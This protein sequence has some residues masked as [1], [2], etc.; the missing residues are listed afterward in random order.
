MHFILL[1]FKL[2]WKYTLTSTF[3]LSKKSI[4]QAV[5]QFI[6]FCKKMAFIYMQWKWFNVGETRDYHFSDN[7]NLEIREP[8]SWFVCLR[9]CLW[10]QV[11]TNRRSNDHFECLSS[12]IS[13]LKKWL[14]KERSMIKGLIVNMNVLLLTL[15]SISDTKSKG[16]HNLRL[17]WSKLANSKLSK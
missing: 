9:R 10:R 3:V 8:L 14:I 12:S 13:K 1:V 5:I 11:D 15:L 16:M 6:E 17:I 4:I 2:F 7:N